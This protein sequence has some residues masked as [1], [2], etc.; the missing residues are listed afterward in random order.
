M[1]KQLQKQLIG[2]SWNII[3]FSDFYKKMATNMGMQKM[4]VKIHIDIYIT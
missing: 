2:T 1:R 3:D 4:V